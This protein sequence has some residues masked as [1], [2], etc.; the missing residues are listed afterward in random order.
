MKY[1]RQFT[2]GIFY[3]RKS[4]IFE[5]SLFYPQIENILEASLIP[6][7]AYMPV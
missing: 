5:E 1:S 2:A 3:C 4:N 6:V 7:I